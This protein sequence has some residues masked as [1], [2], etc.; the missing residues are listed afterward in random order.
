MEGGRRAVLAGCNY[1]GTMA[2]LHGCVNDVW[3]MHEVLCQRFKFRKEDIQVLV[4]DDARFTQPTGAN[5]RRALVAMAASAQPGHA[6]FFH[7]S[8]HG[9]RLPHQTTRA[10]RT[11]PSETY[12][13]CIVPCDMNL[14]TDEDFREI[15]NL[16][17]QGVTFTIVADSCHSGGLI[18]YEKEQIGDSFPHIALMKNY[19]GTSRNHGHHLPIL[20][21]EED[22][23]DDMDQ[24]NEPNVKSPRSL[25]PFKLVEI[26][27]QRSG[28]EDI[29]IKN[30][31]SIIF[32]MFKEESSIKIQKLI[33]SFSS[34]EEVIIQ[35]KNMTIPLSHHKKVFNPNIID[36]SPQFHPHCRKQSAQS[37]DDVHDGKGDM[38]ILLSACQAY[39]TAQDI[40]PHDGNPKRAFGAMSHAIHD[41]L[42][43][44]EPQTPITNYDLVVNVRKLLAQQ[45]SSHQ[46][47]GLYCSDDYVNASFILGKF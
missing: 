47:P 14:L 13:E 28:Q 16:L 46:H 38:A 22:S 8:G 41:V 37:H 19:A 3:S 23:S 36:H 2:E 45:G 29:K 1:K 18:R 12:D 26:L 42:A 6:L 39:E 9:T 32:N 25:P 43:Q 44:L 27:K 40:V 21:E 7:Y 31:R 4:D 34:R 24:H 11:P 20:E 10:S 5:I 33:T 15:I 35:Q 17:P 30:L